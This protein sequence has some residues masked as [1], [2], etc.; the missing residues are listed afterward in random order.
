MYPNPKVRLAIAPK[1][2]GEEEKVGLALNSLR[3]TDPTIIIEHS[4]ELRQTIIHCQGELHSG[5]IKYRLLNRYSVEAEYNEPRVPYRE[6]IQK[7]ANANY[8]HKKQSGGAGQFAEVHMRIEPYIENAPNPG[9]LTV[10]GRDL[11]P[12]D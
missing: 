6:T 4:Q 11:I 7:L 3:S 8:R 5:I 12:L 1:T 10:R 2:K 9:D